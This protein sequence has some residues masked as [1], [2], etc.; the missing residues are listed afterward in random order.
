[1]RPEMGVSQGDQCKW[2]PSRHHMGP[3]APIGAW[4]GPEAVVGRASG[5][6]DPAEK[7]LTSGWQER[8]LSLG[9]GGEWV[10]HKYKQAWKVQTP[11]KLRMKN[12]THSPAPS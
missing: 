5:V 2:K 6:P 1:M 4:E 3:A 7:I 10:T 9:A 11:H 12:L 8:P